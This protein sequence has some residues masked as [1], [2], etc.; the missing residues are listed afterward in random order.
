MAL[1]DIME[2]AL[3]YLVASKHSLVF[4]FLE[5]SMGLY[6]AFFPAISQTM[7]GNDAF[8]PFCFL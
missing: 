3:D 4:I 8:P 2:E 1:A 5:R 6:L 7:R